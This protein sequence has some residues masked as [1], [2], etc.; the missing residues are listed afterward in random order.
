[1]RR[2][3]AILLFAGC[4]SHSTFT[5]D[6]YRDPAATQ[7]NFQRIA[8]IAIARDPEVRRAAED[9]MVAHLGP[10]GVAS[11][12]LLSDADERSADTVR[13][14]LQSANFD[15]AVTMKMLS[16]GEEPMDVRGNIP[17]PYKAFSGHSGAGEYRPVEREQVVRIETQIFSVRENKVLWSTATKSFSPDSV[18]SVVTDV[19]KVIADELRRDGLIQ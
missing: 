16:N 10:K 6:V 8:A 18:K 1:M 12:T 14:K 4:A 9:A 19:A 13:A 3:L 2:T 15:G 17:D 11:Y 7:L 5:T